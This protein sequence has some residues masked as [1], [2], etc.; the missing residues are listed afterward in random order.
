[1]VETAKLTASDG[2]QG[3]L[4]GSSVS[5]SGEILVAGAPGDSSGSTYL[6]E[7]PVTGWPASMTETAKLTPSDGA[8]GDLFGHSVSISGEVVAVGAH[9]DDDSS[10]KAGSAYLFVRPETGWIGMSETDKVTASDGAEYD[11]FGYS[12][13][14]SGDTVVAG[15][16]QDD[17]KGDA[18]GSAYLFSRFKPVAWNYLPVVQRSAP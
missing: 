6:F 14:V 11:Q 8:P 9:Y 15:A 13:S 10:Y 7:K 17:D 16:A 2:T 1:M 5:I 18:S 12:V 3:D 4:F